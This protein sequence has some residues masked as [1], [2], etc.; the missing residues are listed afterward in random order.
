MSPAQLISRVS[1]LLSISLFAACSAPEPLDNVV[2]AENPETFNYVT[3]LQR[4]VSK[5]EIFDQAGYYIVFDDDAREANITISNLVVEEGQAPLTLTFDGAKMD[6]TSNQHNTQRILKADVLVSTDPVNTGTQI[7]N[8]TIIHS[9]ANDLDPYGYGGLFAS[10]CVDNRY[11]V[12]SFPYHIFLDGTTR[13]NSSSGSVIEYDPT[14]R[15]AL[16]PGDMTA[17]LRVCD[18]TV[19]E[20]AN[21]NF[22]LPKLQ[23]TLSESGFSATSTDPINVVIDGKKAT[24]ENVSLATHELNQLKYSM[25]VL[26]NGSEFDIEGFLTAYHTHK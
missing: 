13:V 15:I 24:V 22:S 18:L 19:G 2:V 20:Y 6:F 21:V 16:N 1:I 9:Q 7:T 3:S 17:T 23:L 5:P 10:Y 14:Y 12:V 4:A 11:L 8:V 25:H 26:V